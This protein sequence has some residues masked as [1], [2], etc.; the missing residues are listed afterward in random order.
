LQIGA[1]PGKG[2]V[3]HEAGEPRESFL[4][5]VGGVLA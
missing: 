3:R 2:I 4:H 5:K 1:R